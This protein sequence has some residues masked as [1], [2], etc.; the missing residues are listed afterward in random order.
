[1]AQLHLTDL[2]AAIAFHRNRAP[3]GSDLSLHTDLK[4]LAIVYAEMV[5]RGSSGIDEDDLTP[6]AQF[7]WLEWY[8]TTPDT[9]CIAICSTSQG[10]ENCKGC[11]R[12]FAEVQHW[13]GMSPAEKRDTWK[14]ITLEFD[15]WRFNRYAE[16]AIKEVASDS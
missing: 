10:D 12:T 1:M 16:R 11:G 15:A 5:A 3:A 6:E 8:S 2:E 4:A 9:P 14:R 7:A 13:P